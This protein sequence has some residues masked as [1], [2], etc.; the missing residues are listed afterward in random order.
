MAR[1][2]WISLAKEMGENS[3]VLKSKWRGLRDNFRKELTKTKKG[4][5]GDA[6]GI[7]IPSKWFY[8]TL[9]LFLKD[10]MTQRNATGNIP[11]LNNQEN[12]Y[13]ENTTPDTISEPDYERNHNSEFN[14][15]SEL[16]TDTMPT[17]PKAAKI[18]QANKETGTKSKKAK[19]SVYEKM[20]AIEEEKLKAY[21]EKCKERTKEED[22]D[23]HFL[24]SL[25]PYMKKIPE[26]QKLSVR[27]KIQQFL[28]DAQ[29]RAQSVRTR[30]TAV[31]Q[32]TDQ[33]RYQVVL[34]SASSENE[35]G[36]SDVRKI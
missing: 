14:S 18:A 5:S 12:S 23:F 15:D 32:E 2:M 8:F 13:E 11:P 9:M 36:C 25:M 20:I 10:N 21:R 1:K 29:P 7:S 28:L 34:P 31:D 22:S 33:S 4:R 27:I 35:L 3:D 19:S 16:N 17:T 24:M 6:G 30:T 26:D